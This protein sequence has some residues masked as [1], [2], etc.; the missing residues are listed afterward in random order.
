MCIDIGYN[1]EDILITWKAAMSY[2][3]CYKNLL[4]TVA[5]FSNWLGPKAM[6]IDNCEFHSD[7]DLLIYSYNPFERIKD[8]GDLSMLSFQSEIKDRMV[9]TF[10]RPSHTSSNFYRDCLPI[11]DTLL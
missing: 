2:R 11:D 10:K 3:D 5:D 9:G 6:W 7:E 1:I 4:Y 8:T